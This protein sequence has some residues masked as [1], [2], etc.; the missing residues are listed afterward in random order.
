MACFPLGHVLSSDKI[1][2]VE[3]RV[4]VLENRLKIM[5][6]IL[7]RSEIKG[8]L[9]QEKNKVYEKD[10]RECLIADTISLPEALCQWAKDPCPPKIASLFAVLAACQESLQHEEIHART[11]TIE[12]RNYQPCF[13]DSP[14]LGVYKTEDG[15]FF[16][17]E[18]NSVSGCTA[19]GAPI[20][21]RVISENFKAALIQG[22]GLCRQVRQCAEERAQQC[23]PLMIEKLNAIYQTLYDIQQDLL[24]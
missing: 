11:T 14:V 21:E 3:E 22:D 17:V 10:L 23:R 7:A 2:T 5:G 15:H 4:S 12:P 6:N 16:K 1:E 24:F 20:L 13:S 18:G 9:N 19:Q 8:L